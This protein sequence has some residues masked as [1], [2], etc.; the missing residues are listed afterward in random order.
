MNSQ[1]GQSHWRGAEPFASFFTV[2]EIREIVLPEPFWG[3]QGT[4]Q[5]MS[6]KL[7]CLEEVTVQKADE[8]R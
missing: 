5:R 4:R 1:G 3:I 2:E 6:L 8:Y 7:K